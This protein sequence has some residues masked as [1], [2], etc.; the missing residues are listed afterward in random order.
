VLAE[1][2]AVETSKTTGT[3]DDTWWETTGPLLAELVREQ[4]YPLASRVGTAAGL[5]YGSAFSAD[6]VYE[7]GLARFLD[8]IQQLLALPFRDGRDL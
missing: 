4:D 7:F 5:A 6:A 1:V 3:D 8:G 2:Q